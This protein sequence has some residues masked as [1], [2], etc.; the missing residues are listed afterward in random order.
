MA[1]YTYG[2]FPLHLCKGEIDFDTAAVKALLVD[3]T[4]S[5]DIDLH[6]VRSQLSGEISGTGYSSGGV[7][8]TG[9]VVIYDPNTNTTRIDA[10]DANF[11]IV[12]LSDVAGLVVYVDTGTPATSPLVSFHQMP[13]QNPD[14]VAF[15]YTWNADGILT[16]AA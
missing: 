2:N 10:D 6:D 11:G 13:S 9:V 5:I 3:S 8:L 14:G 12:T 15:V 7:P 16:L 1:A 4:Y